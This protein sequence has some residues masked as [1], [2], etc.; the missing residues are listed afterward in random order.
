MPSTTLSLLGCLN[1]I[2]LWSSGRTVVQLLKRVTQLQLAPALGNQ[3]LGLYKDT[4][5]SDILRPTLRK[6]DYYSANNDGI[7]DSATWLR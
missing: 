1:L 3:L 5:V 2:S 7:L 6:V 4:C